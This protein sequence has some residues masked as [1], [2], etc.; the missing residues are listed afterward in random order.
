MIIEKFIYY[1]CIISIE[2]HKRVMQMG[3]D[4]WDWYFVDKVVSEASTVEEFIDL[5][6]AYN[7]DPIEIA[8]DTGAFDVEEVEKA[9]SP[10]SFEG[11]N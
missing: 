10:N 6:E 3:W 1:K 9:L 11:V 5:C 2:E 7:L 4:G 8:E